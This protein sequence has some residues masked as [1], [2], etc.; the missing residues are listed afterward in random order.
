PIREIRT[1]E[2]IKSWPIGK[3]TWVFDLGENISGWVRLRFHEPA[4]KVLRVRCTEMC[5]PETDQLI[6]SPLSFWWCHGEPQAYSLICDGKARTWQPKFSYFGFRYVEVSGLS[7]APQSDDCLGVVVNTDVAQ[8][9]TFA[10]SDPLLNR[11]FRMG[12]QTHFNNMHS[13]L[14]DCP[15]REKCMWGGDLHASWSVGFHALDS[16]AFYRNVVDLYYTPPFSK[17]GVPG[18]VGVGKRLATHFSDFTWAVSPLFLTYRLYELDGELDTARKHY[19][20]MK[21]FLA[22]FE[23]QAPDYIPQQAAHGDHA[24]PTDIERF[25]QDKHLI[26]AMNFFAAARRFAILA[27]A[28]DKPDDA[29]WARDLAGRIQQSVIEQFYD[30]QKH[31]FGN[32]THDSLA[33]AF[34]LVDATEEPKLAASLAGHYRRNG[35]QFDGGFMSYFIYPALAEWGQ[36]DLA[37]EMLRSADYPGLAWS[38]KHYDATAVWERFPLDKFTRERNSHNH[39]AMNHP[40]GWMLTHLAGIQ[41]KHGDIV[42]KPQIPTDLDWVEASVR[43]HAGTVKSTWRKENGKVIWTFVIPA[44]NRAKVVFPEGWG[45][46]NRMLPSGSYTYTSN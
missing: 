25:P 28:L 38:I 5:N 14:E 30:K 3:E 36:V 35:K 9:A 45:Q 1:I 16:T 6:N 29:R 17:S 11:M 18:N 15:H 39:H 34:E 8:T 21:W 31:S 4:G 7:Q 44:N 20:K 2:P 13:I 41:A 24:E 12:V 22:T 42:L 33:L 32:G 37:L 26:A 23:K 27:D 10:S 40:S 19:D 46:S 43:T